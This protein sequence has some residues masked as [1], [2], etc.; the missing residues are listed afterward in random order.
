MY[1]NKLRFAPRLGIAH[2]FDQAGVVFH[3]AYGI[4]YTPVDL[5]H[6]VQPVA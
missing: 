1:P 5:E 4:F 3:A 6:V 2:H